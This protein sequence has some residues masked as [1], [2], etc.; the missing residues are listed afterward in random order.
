MRPTFK[1]MLCAIFALAVVGSVY[2]NEAELSDVAQLKWKYRVVIINSPEPEKYA[3]KV[4]GSVQQGLADRDI[5]WFIINDSDGIKTNY[6]GA[7]SANFVQ[8][9]RSKYLNSDVFVTLVGKDGGIKVQSEEMN[10]I[11][12]FETIDA[13][14]M[15]Q[16]EMHR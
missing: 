12:L 2:G 14:P 6:Q 13:M 7:I 3:E 8:N 5:A 4:L 15:R 11:A 16:Q 1:S 10:L 9:T